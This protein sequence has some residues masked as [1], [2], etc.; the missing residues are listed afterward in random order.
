MLVTDDLVTALAD[1][2]DCPPPI[3][4]SEYSEY[5]RRVAEAF[6]ESIRQTNSL[7]EDCE[8]ITGMMEG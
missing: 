1:I 7:A 8:K 5:R 3:D 4:A 6:V 2:F